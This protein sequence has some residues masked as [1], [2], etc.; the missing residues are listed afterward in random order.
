MLYY[1]RE[2]YAWEE[3]AINSLLCILVETFHNADCVVMS[4]WIFTICSDVFNL[5][6]NFKVCYSNFVLPNMYSLCCLC[7][8]YFSLKFSLSV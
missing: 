2:S 1:S 7:L 3:F 6:T 5:L 8:N 4:P